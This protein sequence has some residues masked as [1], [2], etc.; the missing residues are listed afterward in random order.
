LGMVRNNTS[1]LNLFDQYRFTTFSH[2]ISGLFVFIL[3]LLLID[4]ILLVFSRLFTPLLDETAPERYGLSWH[5]VGTRFFRLGVL[6]AALTTLADAAQVNSRLFAFIRYD[7]DFS[8]AEEYVLAHD[9]ENPFPAIHQGHSPFAFSNYHHETRS[10]YLNE[11]WI[12]SAL[13]SIIPFENGEIQDLPR[14][15]VVW[16]DQGR[17]LS[18]NFVQAYDYQSRLCI[19]IDTFGQE[20]SDPC[21]LD[22]REAMIVFEKPDVLPYAFSAAVETIVNAPGTIQRDNVGQA[23]LIAHQQDTIIIYA[24]MLLDEEPRH[25]IVQETHFPGWTATIDG[26]PAPT[27]TVGRYIGVPMQPGARTYTL[28]FEPPGFAI[29]IITF[30]VTVLVIGFYLRGKKL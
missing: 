16:S 17:D 25:L 2:V 8:P 28:R 26:V 21:N 7:S 12:P 24:E 27:V 30:I 14:W 10:W 15:A 1:L 22:I 11:G 29:G 20:V 5:A 6:L 18:E 19:P 3:A 9:D 23:K 4:S 13:P